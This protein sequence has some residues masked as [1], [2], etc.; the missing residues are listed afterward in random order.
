MR[1]HKKEKMNQSLPKNG[2]VFNSGGFTSSN[3]QII[4]DLDNKTINYKI[5]PKTEE[6]VDLSEDNLKQILAL[7][8]KIQNS[9]KDFSNFPPTAD[10]T[11][12]L[13]LINNDIHKTIE[14]YGPPIDEV[15]QL[16]TYV[17]NLT[18]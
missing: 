3:R 12:N 11:V 7:M 8:Y 16:Y 17:W 13:I 2:I 5:D 18:S 4:V 14:S 15:D 10:F 1:F 6:K 9:Q